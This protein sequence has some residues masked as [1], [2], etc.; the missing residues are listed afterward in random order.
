DA[1]AQQTGASPKLVQLWKRQSSQWVDG[2]PARCIPPHPRRE[3][4]VELV[5]AGLCY[6]EVERRLGVDRALVGT[7][8]RAAGIR[9]P[10]PQPRSPV[11]LRG[12]ELILL[13]WRDSEIAA[14]LC[15]STQ[16]V[17]Q[18]RHALGV[19]AVPLAHPGKHEAGELLLQGTPA[20][21]VAARIG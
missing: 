19:V 5:R 15:R 6:A 17:N 8:A 3:E 1:V 18:W 2:P 9:T 13:G 12:E 10:G 7:W 20:S 21:E 11:R 4:A 14:E 16:L